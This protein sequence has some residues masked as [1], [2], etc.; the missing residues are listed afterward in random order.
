[1]KL[2]SSQ[3]TKKILE[4]YIEYQYLF[5]EFQSKFLTNLDYKYNSLESGNLVVYFKRQTHQNILRQKDYDL[6]HNVSREKIWEN[7]RAIDPKKIS[8]FKIATD[9]YLPKETAR[10]KILQLVNQKVLNKKNKNIMWLPNEQHKKNY[11]SVIDEEIIDV[12]KLIYFVCE[13]IELNISSEKIIKELKENFSFYWFHYLGAQLEYFKLWNKQFN[14]LELI[15]IFIQVSYLFA[16]KAKN[17]SHKNLYED[18]SILKE[19]IGASISAT[20]ISE[21]TRIP[22]VTCVRKLENLV[23]LKMIK[24][25]NILKRYY[26]IP[27]VVTEELISKKVT[28]KAVELFSN[29]FFICIRAISSKT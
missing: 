4:H 23:K 17:I 15:H 3:I 1:M 10:R 21:V 25:D 29:F 6:N 24:K 12:S 9:V 26:L 18:P 27:N 13:K 19:F 28:E 16:S 11:D 7:H 20:S 22:R 2:L 5:L 14:D 8:I